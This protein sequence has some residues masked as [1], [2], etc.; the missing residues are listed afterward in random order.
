MVSTWA[1]DPARLVESP[2][3]TEIVLVYWPASWLVAKLRSALEDVP[4]ATLVTPER[5]SDPLVVLVVKS[6]TTN[7]LLLLT[8]TFAVTG[9]P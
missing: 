9:A 3:T 1:I 5:L 7:P 4:A 2:Y 8:P 6:P